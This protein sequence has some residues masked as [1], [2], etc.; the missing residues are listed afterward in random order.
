MNDKIV[1]FICTDC[2]GD[3]F[4]CWHRTNDGDNE[5]PT[6]C[7]YHGEAAFW[8]LVEDGDEA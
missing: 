5:P 3:R 8:R 1:T 2:V 7:P 6:V 4:P